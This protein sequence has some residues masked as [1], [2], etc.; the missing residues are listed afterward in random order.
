MINQLDS[1]CGNAAHKRCWK[2][3]NIAKTC[4][5]KFVTSP[6]FQTCMT[7]Q[8]I[9]SVH[10]DFVQAMI[11]W[12][13][14]MSLCLDSSGCFGCSRKFE[15]LQQAELNISDN[16]GLYFFDTFGPILDLTDLWPL[17]VISCFQ[18]DLLGI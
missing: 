13:Q 4:E 5:A 3:L 14:L 1:H 17:S 2:T 6:K 11:K 15:Q 18:H 10:K 8:D 12:H 9:K 16:Q 7:R